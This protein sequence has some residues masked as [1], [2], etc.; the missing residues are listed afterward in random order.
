MRSIDA[1]TLR[2]LLDRRAKECT[3]CGERVGKRRTTWCSDECVKTFKMT[4]DAAFQR[5]FVVKRDG[6]VCRECG[7]ST[8]RC[9]R[10]AERL[11]K[12]RQFMQL[13]ADEKKAYDKRMRLLVE[14]LGVRP[15]H[16]GEVD[17]IE[18]VV[19]GGGLTG[20]ENLRWLCLKCHYA[21]KQA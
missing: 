1:A 12:D 14:Y 17:H 2:W 19:D 21:R 5:D 11:V 15:Y 16:H 6:C 7:R 13:F 18:P 9:A 3:W 4:C 8:E 20:P 10:I